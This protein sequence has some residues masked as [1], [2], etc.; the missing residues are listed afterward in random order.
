MSIKDNAEVVKFVEDHEKQAKAIR[1]EALRLCWW[2]RGGITYDEA[3][4]L[5]SQD[6]EIISNIIKDNLE[7]GKKSGIPIF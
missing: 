4:M 7:A 5:S 3:M 6:R 1:E 2:M